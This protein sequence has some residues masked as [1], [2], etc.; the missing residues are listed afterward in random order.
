M[1]KN[2]I[3]LALVSATIVCLAYFLNNKCNDEEINKSTMVK[4]SVIAAGVSLLTYYFI[5]S[6]ESV[7]LPNQDVL[8]GDPGF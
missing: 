8:T 3:V 6:G 2:P 1:I 4:L 7:S 5:N